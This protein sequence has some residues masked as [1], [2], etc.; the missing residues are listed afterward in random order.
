MGC[1]GPSRLLCLLGSRQP[2]QG[3][4][5]THKEVLKHDVNDDS[6][7][8]TRALNRRTDSRRKLICSQWAV[9][10]SRAR[11]KRIRSRGVMRSR[12]CWLLGRHHVKPWYIICHERQV[13]RGRPFGAPHNANGMLERVIM[14]YCTVLIS[15]TQ[16][17]YE[18]CRL[19]K[20]LHTWP[21]IW[22]E[23]WPYSCFCI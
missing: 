19:L 7:A 9:T 5:D 4:Q 16:P 21:R 12:H 17:F 8:E 15:S 10:D 11:R 22:E 6:T 20:R 2:C 18:S 1:K 13:T 14:I 23:K 3:T